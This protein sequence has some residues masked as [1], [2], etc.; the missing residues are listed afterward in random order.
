MNEEDYVK[1]LFRFYSN[2]LDKN[3]VE[4]VWAKVVDEEKGFYQIENIPFYIPNIASD[5]IVHA[6]FDEAEGHLV[7]EGTVEYS[8]NSLIRVFLMKG[9]NEINSLRDIFR[10][11][12]C[13]SERVGDNY[14]VMEIPKKVNYQ[15]VKTRLQDLANEGIIDYAE[16]VLLDE[17]SENDASLN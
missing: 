2:L 12:D 16:T 15:L 10:K 17:H 3:M 9:E 6:K 7:F 1:I 4:T 13:T 11:M 5:D 8:G 14:F